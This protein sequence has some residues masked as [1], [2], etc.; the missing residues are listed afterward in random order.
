MKIDIQARNFQLT[1]AL[2]SYIKRRL[3]FMLSARDE[4]IQRVLVRLSEVNDPRGGIGK[5]CHI[6]VALNNLPDIIIKDAEADLYAAIDR[7]VDRAGRTV[8][9]QLEWQRI[10]DS[11]SSLPQMISIVK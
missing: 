8:C 6:Q 1:D 9:R 11:S 7:A 4:H 10:R 5:C 3:S 2:C